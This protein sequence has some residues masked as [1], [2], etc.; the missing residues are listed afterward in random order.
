MSR[1]PDIR[2]HE[3]P[4]FFRDAVNFT[5]ARTAFI[6]RLIEKDY[7]CTLL[8]EYLTSVAPDLIFKGGTCLAKVHAGFYRLSEDLDFVIP[9]SVDATRNERRARAA[10]LKEA[11]VELPAILPLFRIA[12]PLTGANKSTQYVATVGYKSITTGQED[13]IKIEI[14]LR[15][16]LLTDVLSTGARTILLDP[17]SGEPLVKEIAIRAISRVEA[18]AEKFRAALSRRDAAIRDFFDLDYAERRLE[19]QLSEPELI[20]LVR[21]KLMIPGNEEVNISEARLA[22]LNAQ[23]ES[24]LKPVLREVDFG[25]FQLDRAYDL[26]RS[27]AKRLDLPAE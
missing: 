9:M 3:D 4:D 1:Q 27:M 24:Q 5:A 12:E 20:T 18:F 16:P 10:P 21:K 25:E 14:G 26:V 6:T 15:E 19:L 7:F 11:I 22:A 2:L 13:M 17:I 23:L 8:L